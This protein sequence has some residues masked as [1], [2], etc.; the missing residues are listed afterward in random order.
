MDDEGSEVEAIKEA[1]ALR[2]AIDRLGR[3]RAKRV[4]QDCTKISTFFT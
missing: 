2:E 1:K 4:L 3:K